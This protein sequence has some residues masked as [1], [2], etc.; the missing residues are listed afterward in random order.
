MSPST[1]EHLSLQRL[2]ND[3]ED[4]ASKAN[5]SSSLKFSSPPNSC[6]HSTAIGPCHKHRLYC[7]PESPSNI[8]RLDSVWP[9]GV[10]TLK[11]NKLKKKKRKKT[12]T[13]GF[14]VR[15]LHVPFQ[16]TGEL[17]LFHLTTNQSHLPNRLA[18][19]LACFLAFRGPFC[20]TP[21]RGPKSQAPRERLLYAPISFLTSEALAP[22]WQEKCGRARQR[23]CL[24][25]RPEKAMLPRSPPFRYRRERDSERL[26]GWP[27]S[28]RLSGPRGARADFRLPL[29]AAAR[30]TRSR[31]GPAAAQPRA[32]SADARP[33]LN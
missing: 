5:R 11:K 28:R 7:Q 2:C 4:R 23:R 21:G 19:T 24:R 26:A 32:S 1:Q 12:R 13:R 10:T 25:L 15:F 30:G 29:S 3:R 9:M 27:R 31:P 16:E 22:R 14:S 8:V 17:E 6:G 33:P 20:R 18:N